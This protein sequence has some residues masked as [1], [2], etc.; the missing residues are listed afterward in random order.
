VKKLL[1]FALAILPVWSFAQE[2]GIGLRVGEPFSVTYKTF[3]DDNISIEGMFGRAGI[4]SAQY[5]IR[6]FENN[7]P[8]PNAFYGGHSTSNSYSLNLRAAYHENF[9]TELDIQS[10]YL[11]GYVG[12]GAQL[13]TA[14]VDYAYT[15]ATR[16]TFGVFRDNRTNIDFGPEI[17][18]GAE[19]YFDELPM[20]VFVEIGAFMELLDR[21]GHLRLQGAIGVRYLF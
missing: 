13:R 6:A 3:L 19:Y 18:G 8:T 21:F 9:T 7:R 15:D 10:G 16:S 14:R 4:N 12:L 11:L 1:I 5:Y 17:F 2:A 20:N